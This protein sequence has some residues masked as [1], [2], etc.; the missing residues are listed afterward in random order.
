[1]KMSLDDFLRTTINDVLY[2]RAGAHGRTHNARGQNRA[3]YLP[4]IA[5]SV[6]LTV[7]TSL[8]DH[9]I[10]PLSCSERPRMGS[11]QYNGE[12]VYPTISEQ[13]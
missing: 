1:M 8:T 11:S 9:C 7:R 5:E 12:R 4:L 3:M 10:P 13:T 2:A 6:L